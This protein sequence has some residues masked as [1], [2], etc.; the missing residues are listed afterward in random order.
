MSLN[1]KKFLAL[2]AALVAGGAMAQGYPA[3][4]I[5]LV[6]PA[7][8]GGTTDLAGRM[9]AQALAPRIRVNAIGPGPTLAE[10]CQSDAAF[11]RSQAGAPLGYAAAPDDICD[12]TMYLLAATS[13]T[14]Q[15][16]SV[17]GGKHID[18]PANRGPTPRS[19]A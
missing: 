7:A 15:M 2:A 5:T 11:R 18:F 1:R 12:A 14:G 17:D 9:L 6:V 10:A 16:I 4:P 19:G 8:A 13:V 3:K